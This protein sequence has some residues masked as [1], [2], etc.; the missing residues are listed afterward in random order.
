MNTYIVMS[1]N[2]DSK[3]Y[4]AIDINHLRANLIRDVVKPNSGVMILTKTAKPLGVLGWIKK[5]K[6]SF[7]VYDVTKDFNIK[8]GWVVNTSGNLVRRVD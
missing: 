3:E 2:G 1:R 5:G 6:Y 8:S 4:K 7:Y